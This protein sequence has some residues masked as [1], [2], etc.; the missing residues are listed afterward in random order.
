MQL[1][2]HL[3]LAGPDLRVRETE[4]WVGLVHRVRRGSLFLSSAPPACTLSLSQIH[5][6]ISFK[7]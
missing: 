3:A 6:E 1:V 5:K 7:K 2:W 4:P